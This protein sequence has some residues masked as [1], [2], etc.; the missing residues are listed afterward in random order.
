MRRRCRNRFQFQGDGT[1][2]V[3]VGC[4]ERLNMLNK[5][6]ASLNQLPRSFQNLLRLPQTGQSIAMESLGY[7]QAPLGGP[8]QFKKLNKITTGLPHD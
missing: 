3:S 4:R 1:R 2:A 8:H 5:G 6:I 7:K